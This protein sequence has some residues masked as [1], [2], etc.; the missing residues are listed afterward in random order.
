LKP[1]FLFLKKEI[2]EEFKRPT[3]IFGVLLYLVSATF[4]VALVTK[5]NV[6]PNIWCAFFWILMTFVSFNLLN[7]HLNYEE[8]KRWNY[9]F[10]LIHPI[11]MIIARIL[12]HTIFLW[13]L[14]L[15][16]YFLLAVWI[17]NPITSNDVFLF[18]IFL[19]GL[20]F[21]SSLT[22]ISSIALQA[23]HP[24]MIMSVLGFPLI[25]PL[26]WTLI[27]VSMLSI[28]GFRFSELQ[29]YWFFFASIIIISILLSIILFPIIWKE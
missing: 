8:I 29:N 22:L 26:I 11:Q 21:A 1:I 18:N 14:G 6:N 20:G 5:G 27:K 4:I 15:I 2:N 12:F 24:T 10:V 7:K 19:G 16:N 23:N 3:N 17:K 13:F 25:I 28:Q 9:Y